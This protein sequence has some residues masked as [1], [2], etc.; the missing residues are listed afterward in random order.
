MIQM[1]R[2]SAYYKE[3]AYIT[4]AHNLLVIASTDIAIT[5]ERYS[6]NKKLTRRLV[7]LQK[8]LEVFLNKYL[9][10]FDKIN[11]HLDKLLWYLKREKEIQ[12]DY[13]SCYIL[14]TR[15]MEIRRGRILHEDFKWLTNKDG[16][17]LECCD[18]LKEVITDDYEF[19]SLKLATKLAEVL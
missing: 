8:E 18:L 16:L 11:I 9:S 17:M 4:L 3:L 2:P 7:T 6:A 14:F 13:L 10:E 5:D 1:N 19:L 15:F 12:P